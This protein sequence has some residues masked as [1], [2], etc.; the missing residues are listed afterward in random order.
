MDEKTWNELSNA[1]RA[2]ALVNLDPE[3]ANDLLADTPQEDL[4]EIVRTQCF[5]LSLYTNPGHPPH[6]PTLAEAE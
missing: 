2:D 4:A 5:R 1:E 6:D 3:L